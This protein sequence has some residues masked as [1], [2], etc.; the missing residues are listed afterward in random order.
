MI[1][2]ELG[3]NH[4]GNVNIAKSLIDV[5]VEAGVDAIK[6]QKRTVEVV[7]TANELSKER[8]SP[9]GITYA[10]Y[11]YGLEFGR[12]EKE[13]FDAYCQIDDY[14]RQKGV[15]WFASCWDE[16]AVDFVAQFSPPCYKIA[17]ASLT[18]DKLLAYTKSKSMP[19]ILSTGMS[20]ES[21]I[22][23]AVNVLGAKT[24]PDWSISNP[25]VILLHCVA[26]YPVQ[27]EEIDCLNLAVIDTLRKRYGRLV[28]YSGHETGVSPSV[29][30][31]AGYGACMV[32]RHITLNRAMWGSDQ[33]A[34]LEPKGL[35]LLVRDI[36]LWERIKGD[37]VK[38]L[39]DIEVPVKEKLRRI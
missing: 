5:A 27:P 31:V 2:A 28:G 1:V 12:S 37:G 35:E 36:R 4:Q 22:D 25:D 29:V 34:S 10:D 7:F 38:R 33:A 16:D 26:K 30:A 17:S 39:L 11:K 8:E 32:E 9:F 20:L 3:I 18:D 19:M 6:L 15:L 14:C 13:Q 23:N 24:E 21:E